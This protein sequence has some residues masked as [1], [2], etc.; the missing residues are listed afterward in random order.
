M[1]KIDSP[2]ATITNEWTE[3]NPSLG[4]PATVVSA[5]FMN[6]AVQGELVEV[7]E[8]AGLVLS[9]VDPTQ[10][11]QAIQSLIGLGGGSQ[12]KF[13]IANAVGPLPVTGLVLDKADFKGAIVH[14]DLERFT[15]TQNVQE[16]GF[17]F[18]THDTDDDVWRISLSSNLDDAGVVFSITGAGEVEYTSDD[19]TGANYNGFIRISSITKFAQ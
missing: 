3:G 18:L 2:G 6:L 17:L 12:I 9:K 16:Q 10:V 7:V 11:R 4:I 8:F 15:D 5:D 14:F 13:A 19:L 1:F